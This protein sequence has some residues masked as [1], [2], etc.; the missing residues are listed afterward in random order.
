M[1]EALDI[2]LPAAIFI[3]MLGIG[4]GLKL[5]DFKRVFVQPK[6][7]LY[8]LFGQLVLMPFIAFIIAFLFPIDPIYKLGIILIAASP[9]GTSS[10]IVSYILRGRVALAVSITAFNSL[11][12]IFTIP[13][14]L[15]LGFIAFWDTPQLINLSFESTVFEVVF[16]VLLPVILGIIIRHFYPDFVKKIQKPL[17]FILPGILFLVFLLVLLVEGDG[18]EKTLIE[19]WGL[20]I[21]AFLLNI[22]VMLVGFYSSGWIGINHRGKYTLAIEMGLQNS[23]L[24]IFIANN[25]IQLDGLALIAVLYGSF[26]F[27]TTLGI[28]YIMKNYMRKEH[29]EL[30]N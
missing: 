10:N 1:K 25:I 19:Y 7:I 2:L 18:S 28:A 27:F 8:G 5:S 24:A 4:L 6:A 29:T 22:V 20:L 14:I 30:E 15:N 21:P 9:G 3:I 11:L 13:I 23:A 26:S 17:R 12:V 16:S